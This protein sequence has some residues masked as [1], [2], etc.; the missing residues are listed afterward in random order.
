[1]TLFYINTKKVFSRICSL[2]K[3]DNPR[4]A[5]TGSTGEMSSSDLPASV[6]SGF[7]LHTSVKQAKTKTHDPEFFSENLAS[8][9]GALGY[10]PILVEGGLYSHQGTTM[11]Q[12]R[13]S[14]IGHL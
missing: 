1:M 6:L 11:M 10:Y 9:N 2:S 13:L 4:K 3:G 12:I 5:T 14:G 7:L 8:L